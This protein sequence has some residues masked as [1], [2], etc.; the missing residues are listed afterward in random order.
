MLHFNK[1]ER[2]RERVKHSKET[3]FDFLIKKKDIEIRLTKTSEKRE[4]KRK[5]RAE[6]RVNEK[7][8]LKG[9][10]KKLFPL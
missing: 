6:K 10:E 2:E 8:S 9:E 4:G 3:L 5:R 1:R 7:L